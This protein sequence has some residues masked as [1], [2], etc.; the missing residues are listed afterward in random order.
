LVC[1]LQAI[2]GE[3]RLR[4]EQVRIER[5]LAREGQQGRFGPSPGQFGARQV[6]A[7]AHGSRI[8]VD[9]GVDARGLV[10]TACRHDMVAAFE[11]PRAVALGFQR[12]PEARRVGR[13]RRRAA[14]GEDQGGEK[15]M[16]SAH[17]RPPRADRYPP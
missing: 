13:F 4:L 1:R 15:E 6:Q 8:V 12:F 3:F 17:G 2:Q 14:T 16:P 11:A 10:E 7:V 9:A 5:G